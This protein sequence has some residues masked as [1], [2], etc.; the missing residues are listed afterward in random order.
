MAHDISINLSSL[1]K[2]KRN[3]DIAVYIKKKKRVD[4]N[5]QA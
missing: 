1:K 4:K 5:S 2:L 3:L